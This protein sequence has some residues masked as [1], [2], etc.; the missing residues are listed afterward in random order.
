M[1]GRNN[2]S[3]LMK[4]VV[5]KDGLEKLQKSLDYQDN[6]NMTSSI[7]SKSK[8]YLR[9]ARFRTNSSLMRPIPV[10]IGAFQN[11]PHGYV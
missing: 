7:A 3:N 6:D 11:V 1:A 9:V 2:P 4:T 5:E 10:G 8:S